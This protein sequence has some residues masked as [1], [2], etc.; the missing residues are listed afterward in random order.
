MT[1]QNSAALEQ[2][3]AQLEALA[4]RDRARLHRVL[5]F[6]T[7]S[8]HG[9]SEAGSDAIDAIEAAAEDTKDRI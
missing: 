1:T 9:S 5:D 2:A 8:Q 4:E 6:F 7:A 3:L